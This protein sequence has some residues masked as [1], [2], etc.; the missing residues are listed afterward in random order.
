M[1]Q[2]LIE[3]QICTLAADSSPSDINDDHIPVEIWQGVLSEQQES[4]D[5]KSEEGSMLSSEQSRKGD[6]TKSKAVSVLYAFGG[7]YKAYIYLLL[8]H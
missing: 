2:F 1:E 3:K 6:I 5:S 4:R 8:G 7:M